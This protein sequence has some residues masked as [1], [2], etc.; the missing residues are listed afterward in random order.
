MEDAYESQCQ[1]EEAAA[2]D[3]ALPVHVNARRDTG[4][5]EGQ[6]DDEQGGGISGAELSQQAAVSKRGQNGDTASGSILAAAL[7]RKGSEMMRDD[8]DDEEAVFDDGDAAEGESL[9][10]ES[11]DDGSVDD[12]ESSAS[13]IVTSPSQPSQPSSPYG[14]LDDNPGMLV[15]ALSP[16][17]HRSLLRDWQTGGVST[18]V[19]EYADYED[20]GYFRVELP[21]SEEPEFLR[22]E[23]EGWAEELEMMH[24][25]ITGGG[26][27]GGGGGGKM[28]QTP[29]RAA[30]MKSV[31]G[32][33]DSGDGGDQPSV[34]GDPAVTWPS[35]REEGDRD[36]GVGASGGGGEVGEIV[37][38]KNTSKTLATN[39]AMKTVAAEVYNNGAVGA[40]GLDFAFDRSPLGSMTPTSDAA[41]PALDW[42]GSEFGGSSHSPM[43]GGGGGTPKSANGLNSHDLNLDSAADAL[44]A[45]A[46]AGG[47]GS[48][49]AGAGGGGGGGGQG[50]RGDDEDED[51][52]TALSTAEPRGAFGARMDEAEARDDVGASVQANAQRKTVEGEDK[53]DDE[54]QGDISAAEPS[55]SGVEREAPPP[56][57]TAAAEGGSDGGVD[58][59]DGSD[60]DVAEEGCCGESDEEDWVRVNALKGRKMQHE[61]LSPEEAEAL[62]RLEMSAATTMVEPA[63]ATGGGRLASVLDKLNL[64]DDDSEEE[65]EEASASDRQ[66][67]TSN[68]TSEEAA[69]DAP[70]R[71]DPDSDPE[72]FTTFN[73]RIVHRLNRTGFEEHKEFP[74]R[75]GS[76]VAGRYQ[77]M[78]YLGSAAFSQ[79]VQALDLQTGMLVCM[80]IIKNNKDFFDQ[81]LDEVKLLKFIN[82]RDPA[83]AKGLLRLYDYF[84]HREHLF[85]VTELLRANL[86]EFQKF[87]LESGDEPYFTLG[88][89]RSIARQVLTSLEFL[90]SLDLI[91]CDLKPENILIKSYS[92]C[93]VKVIDLGSSCYV[94]DHLSS[95][96]QSR[97][98][99]APE[100]ILGAPYSTKV[101]IW[102]LGCILAELHTGEVLFQNDSLASLLARCVGILGPVDPE[103]LARGRYSSRFFT[104]NGL[105]YERD[106][107]TGALHVL[108]PKKT[109]LA[110]RLGFDPA[111]MAEAGAGAG[112]GRQGGGKNAAGFLDLLLWLLQVNPNARPTAAEALAHPWLAATTNEEERED[113]EGYDDRRKADV[114]ADI[115]GGGGGGS[116]RGQAGGEDNDDALAGDARERAFMWQL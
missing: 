76:V 95:Y 30:A 41:G 19:D 84:Y 113:E 69:T 22:R 35:S 89:L 7:D 52:D 38:K 115:G 33:G 51:E 63:A 82:Q 53:D 13:P 8:D 88:S 9:G 37:A 57:S 86:Y 104:R 2:R 75:L 108:Q 65:E 94:T 103:L 93:E 14:F 116:G 15:G 105:V 100:V 111:K 34:G 27:G 54:E 87:N 46:A 12:V 64:D 32:F 71:Q 109:T 49:I 98:Y 78:E 28:G 74:V 114:M 42:G 107:D 72:S 62:R 97:S 56:P 112:A 66:K 102:S 61:M 91:H 21:H 4:K 70:E 58:S 17:T 99:R 40:A 29:A 26:G 73:L 80:K 79:A 43:E 101:D 1:E 6:D 48:P 85:I 18:A 55:S 44:R 39:K 83:D 10:P 60:M 50:G 20:A 16:G 90:H 81:S 59:E 110:A 5:R 31:R 45:W 3:N 96:V 67:E 77:L 68:K 25:H 23:V 92:R 11:E 47:E 24:A 36:G 106:K